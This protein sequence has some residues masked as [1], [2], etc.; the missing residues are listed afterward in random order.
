M[1]THQG[2]DNDGA[3]ICPHW[4]MWVVCCNLALSYRRGAL[5]LEDLVSGVHARASKR[6]HT[7]GKCVTCCGLPALTMQPPNMGRAT[8]ITGH[9]YKTDMW[10]RFIR[11]DLFALIV[12]CV[13][14]VCLFGLNIY[15]FHL[16]L[17]TR[18]SRAPPGWGSMLS[19]SLFLFDFIM[20]MDHFR[21]G[22]LPEC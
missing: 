7:W 10:L 8:Q 16:M 20:V 22:S 2:V 15:L 4:H 21:I 9:A 6:H 3:N 18:T 14:F 19:F 17:I 5:S 11:R 1:Y 12:S 13:I